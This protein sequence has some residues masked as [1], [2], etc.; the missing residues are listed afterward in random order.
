[1]IVG[2]PGETNKD[3]EESLDFI[4]H[5]GFSKVHVFKYSKRPG[6]KAA[7]MPEQVSGEIKNTRSR[8]MIE[9]AESGA[10]EYIDKN[11]G[12]VRQTLVLSDHEKNGDRL[13]RGLTDNGIDVRFPENAYDFKRNEFCNIILKKGMAFFVE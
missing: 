4:K 2:F 6:T 9:A 8:L 3:F 1:V 5:I 11:I 10:K 7:E 12:H 13:I